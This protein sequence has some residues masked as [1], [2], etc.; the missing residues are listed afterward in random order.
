MTNDPFYT[1]LLEISWRRKLTAVEQAELASW[2]QAHPE[3]KPDWDAEAILTDQ[4]NRLSEPELSSNFTARVLE[5][6]ER[7]EKQTVRGRSRWKSWLLRL[8]PPIAATAVVLATL[9][10]QQVATEHRKQLLESVVL[11]SDIK[12]LPSVEILKNF[13]AIR[14]LN[15]APGPDEQL[16]SLLQ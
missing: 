15:S 11:V 2:L 6:I 1:R 10:H 14:E 4:F 7:P 8:A 16:I 3:S 5:Q 9:H 12:S 13:D